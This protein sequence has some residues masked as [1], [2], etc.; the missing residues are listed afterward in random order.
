MEGA[1]STADDDGSDHPMVILR[2]D[3]P[4]LEGMFRLELHS[5]VFSALVEAG[6]ITNGMFDAEQLE[7]WAD[8][9]E[10]PTGQRAAMAR[11]IAQLRR[12]AP[13]QIG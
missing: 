4:E 5:A 13:L 2:P 11:A 8:T 6:A 3:D 12:V 10:N 7:R 9:C 1:A